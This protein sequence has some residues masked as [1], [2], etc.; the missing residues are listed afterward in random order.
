VSVTDLPLDEREALADSISPKR[1]AADRAAQDAQDAQAEQARVAEL[2][3]ISERIE[4]TQFA[5]SDALDEVLAAMQ[6]LMDVREKYASVRAE[7]KELQARARA[8]DIPVPVLEDY[9]TRVL[10]DYEARKLNESWLRL[11]HT[12]LR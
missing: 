3:D 4:P 11:I 7:G 5:V 8:L 1:L 9:A 2:Q 10:T 6:A 12:Q